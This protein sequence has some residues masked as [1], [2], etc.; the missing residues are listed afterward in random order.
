MIFNGGLKVCLLFWSHDSG[1][2]P[3]IEFNL[4]GSFH[5]HIEIDC[6][7]V[8]LKEIP[9]VLNSSELSVLYIS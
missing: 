6:R 9:S 4:R 3:L 7:L 8:A 5:S 2:A 1:V